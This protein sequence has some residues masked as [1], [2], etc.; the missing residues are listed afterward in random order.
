MLRKTAPQ[1]DSTAAF[2]QYCQLG[3]MPFLS[4][5]LNNPEACIH[6]LREVGNT[7]ILKDIISR[8]KIRDINQLERIIRF[9]LAHIGQPFSANSLSKYFK[10]ENRAISTETV[11][12]YIRFCTDACLLHKV[13][14]EDIVGK[15]LLTINEKY[16]V[17]DHGLR[18]ALYGHYQQDIQ[19]VLENMVYLECLRR[20]YTVTT[21]KVGAKE[22]DFIARKHNTTLYIQV[23]YLLASPDTIEREFGVY[24]G[25]KDNYPKFVVSLDEWD[26]SRDGIRHCNI[27]DFLL[28]EDWV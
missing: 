2:R 12:N 28:K 6:Y 9:L 7:I 25:V 22:I 27:R 15:K 11:L 23:A 14:R 26:M 8:H 19:L 18:E 3:G 13:S 10:S 4:N 1:T 24:S 21:G 17:A 5:L 20:D 16:Y